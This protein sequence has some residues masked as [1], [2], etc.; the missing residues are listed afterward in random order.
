MYQRQSC[1]L[2]SAM[3]WRYS[4]RF[5]ARYTPRKAS[6]NASRAQVEASR[7]RRAVSQSVGRRSVAWA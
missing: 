1:S 3:N 2:T 4:A 5:T 6:P 7:A